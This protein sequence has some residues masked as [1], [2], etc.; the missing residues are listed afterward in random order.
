MESDRL[1]SGIDE[2]GNVTYTRPQTKEGF[3]KKHESVYD[4][5][6]DG[7]LCPAN[8]DCIKKLRTVMVIKCTLEPGTLQ[9]LSVPGLMDRE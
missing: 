3:Y 6:D 4:K 9:S 2:H 1:S 8:A 7:Y 5:H